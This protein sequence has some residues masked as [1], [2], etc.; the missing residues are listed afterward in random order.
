MD[1][2]PNSDDVVVVLGKITTDDGTGK[3]GKGDDGSPRRP[4]TILVCPGLI[5]VL[6][7]IDTLVEDNPNPPSSNRVWWCACYFLS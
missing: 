7:R 5:A 2:E 6:V 4:R 3:G 1:A